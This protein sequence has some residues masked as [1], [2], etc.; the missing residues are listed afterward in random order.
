M[1]IDQIA[2]AVAEHAGVTVE[3]LRGP[4]LR[5]EIARPRQKAYVMAA[6]HG[7]TQSEIGRYFNRRN[8]GVSSS[9]ARFKARVSPPVFKSRRAANGR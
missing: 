7:L 8:T 4:S 1:T 5:S 3:D 6:A 9:I 2:R